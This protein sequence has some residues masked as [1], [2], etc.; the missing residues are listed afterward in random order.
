[1]RNLKLKIYETSKFKKLRKKI[2]DEKEMKELKKAI[3]EVINS[4]LSGKKLKGEFKEL[5]SYK[6]FVNGQQR[7]LIYKYKG[8]SVYF[9]TFGPREGIYK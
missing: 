2:K 8:D 6:Y 5:R 4:P 3:I 7:R 9:L 1:M